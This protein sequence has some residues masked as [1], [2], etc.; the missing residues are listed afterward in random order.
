MLGDREEEGD[1]DE[2]VGG[3]ES[4]HDGEVR[5]LNH[6]HR[7]FVLLPLVHHLCKV[8]MSL[9]SGHPSFTT[10]VKWA[11]RSEVDTF[12][13]MCPLDSMCPSNLGIHL[14]TLDHKPRSPPGV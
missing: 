3:V 14:T 7:H 10:F 5:R 9:L 11:Y 12:V 6:V 13:S 2:G 4:I 8:D 1:R